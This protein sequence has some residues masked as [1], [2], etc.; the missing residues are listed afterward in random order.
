MK[1]FAYVRASPAVLSMR[2][3]N[4]KSF[5]STF[6]DLPF[7]NPTRKTKTGT[8]NRWGTTNS[9][10]W[11]PIIMISQSKTLGSSQIIFITLFSV[12]AQCCVAVPFSSNHKLCN[13][14]EPQPFSQPK[15]AISFTFLHPILMCKITYWA[16][17]EM[18]SRYSLQK[19][20]L[21][22]GNWT[23]EITPTRDANLSTSLPN[24][25]VLKIYICHRSFEFYNCFPILMLP[26]LAM[27]LGTLW[28]H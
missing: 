18:L 7:C 17:L 26:F 13:Y 19:P 9:K 16:Q 28:S 3:C 22:M 12:G 25:P 5:T 8:S 1:V 15:P 23:N 10:P 14:A 2:P 21:K 11:G 20:V 6:S 27:R 4:E 24:N